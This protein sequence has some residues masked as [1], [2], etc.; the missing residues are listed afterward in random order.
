MMIS[1]RN[2]L[3]TIVILHVVT[4]LYGQNTQ[5]VL[6]SSDVLLFE[7]KLFQV[8]SNQLYREGDLPFLKQQLAED[9][10]L[11]FE[12]LTSFH[13]HQLI[14]KYRSSKRLPTLYWDD[15]M[16]LA[17][18]N[19][20][21]YMIE[22]GDLT[23]SQRRNNLYFTGSTPDKRVNYVTYNVKEL[24]TNAENCLYTTIEITKSK[25][26]F[27]TV[28][29]WVERD[30]QQI[31]ETA[32]RL[33]EEGFEQWK[34]SSGHNMNMID[35]D[36]FIHGT[37]FSFAGNGQFYGTTVFGGDQR[38]FTK[39]EISIDFDEETALRF[40]ILF[41]ENGKDFKKRPWNISLKEV[42]LVNALI[43]TMN[44]RGISKNQHLYKAAKKHQ[45]DLM[46]QNTDLYAPKK[47][48]LKASN[49]MGIFKTFGHTFE[50][51]S[52]LISFPKSELEDMSAY[53]KVESI[54]ENALKNYSEIKDWGGILKLVEENGVIN[55]YIDV[56][57]MI[58]KP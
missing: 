57:L 6:N 15:R 44:N 35:A 52:F 58:K 32:V 47:G 40:P 50:N 56:F 49:Y 34:N 7:E 9:T 30:I 1:V 26:D 19:H 10:T 41:E 3:F 24:N 53:L 33:A 54:V 42:K 51:I 20:N 46:N 55:C 21:I 45:N 48:Y 13:F 31:E 37:S 22:V 39:N 5:E 2:L 23:H 16:W 4:F 8:K 43:S 17:A 25:N 18:R 29:G 14:N 38:Y 28:K 27:L 12:W 11:I 36:Y